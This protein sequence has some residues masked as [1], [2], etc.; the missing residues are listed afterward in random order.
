MIYTNARSQHLALFRIAVLTYWVIALARRP[1]DDLVR[2]PATWFEPHGPWLF[3][4]ASWLEHLWTPAAIQPLKGATIAVLVLVMVGAKGRAVWSAVAVVLLTTVTAFVRGFGHPDHADVQLLL[5][6]ALL[7][8]TPAWDAYA[9]STNARSPCPNDAR[10]AEAFTALALVFS[11]PYF[12]TAAYRLAKEGFTIFMGPSIMAFLARDS[13]VLDDFT[14][15]YGLLIAE[16]S[17]LLPLLN[18]GFLVTTFAELAAPW[19]HLHRRG[20]L[21]WVVIIL[22]FHLL[23]PFVMHIVFVQNIFL[24]LALYVWPFGW[25]ATGDE[26]EAP[27]ANVS[28]VGA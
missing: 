6:T 23:T 8:V 9:W 15:S 25:R 20:C 10:Y 21:V 16:Q 18:L 5:V 12:L 22:S 14:F 7:M 1:L 13:L 28:E 19:A 3:V 4:P 11:Y 2:L 24:I 17:H 27:R 26:V